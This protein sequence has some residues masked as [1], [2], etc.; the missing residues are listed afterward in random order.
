MVEPCPCSRRGGR[1]RARPAGAALLTVALRAAGSGAAP[2]V[3]RAELLGRAP[4]TLSGAGH[5]IPN[6][7]ILSSS[8]TTT[9]SWTAT[10]IA[11]ICSRRRLQP[12]RPQLRLTAPPLS[13]WL[14][15]TPPLGR[16]A[17]AKT[18]RLPSCLWGED[19]PLLPQLLSSAP[20]PPPPP[21]PPLMWAA[22]APLLLLP[23]PPQQQRP[24]ALGLL[25][26]ALA[27][28]L[29]GI[30]SQQQRMSAAQPAPARA[31]PRASAVLHRPRPL[32][33]CGAACAP[34][35][36]AAAE[37][38]ALAV[39]EDDTAAETTTALDDIS[40]SDIQRRDVFADSALCHCEQAGACHLPTSGAAES[41]AAADGAADE[42]FV[43]QKWGDSLDWALDPS[44]DDDDDDDDEVAY[45]GQERRD[46]VRA[47]GQQQRQ[48]QLLLQQ[49]P[50]AARSAAA[51][52][53]EQ[54]RLQRQEEEQWRESEYGRLCLRH[55]GRGPGQ[56]PREAPFKDWARPGPSRLSFGRRAWSSSDGGS[57]SG[58][59]G[60]SDARQ[61]DGTCSGSGGGDERDRAG[62]RGSSSCGDSDDAA[63]GV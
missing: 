50:A 31:R 57:D 56:S 3:L 36:A 60:G 23:P 49:Q 54:A 26:S 52:A 8:T 11:R 17:L 41:V 29:L 62:S 13:P 12:A 20:P 7:R 14:W 33:L 63:S 1:R 47:A 34:E 6:N 35:P 61:G 22:R 18:I 28:R 39:Q 21:L 45:D 48:R 27:L 43:F 19:S 9:A 32:G 46:D 55:E 16:Q 44:S 42:V 59:S 25:R 24:D 38:A 51:A 2:W 30:L 37:P 4:A 58:S 53:E 40:S 15:A 5:G 10:I